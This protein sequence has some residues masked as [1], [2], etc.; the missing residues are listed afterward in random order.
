MML[1]VIGVNRAELI[2]VKR[3]DFNKHFLVTRGQLYKIYPD[4]LSRC[5]VYDNGDR[6]GDEE[7]IVYP[8]NGIIP[9]H[10]RRQLYTMTKILSEIDNHKNCVSKKGIFGDSLAAIGSVRSVWREISFM[11][12]MVVAGAILLYAMVFQ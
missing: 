12:P 1:F 10:P 6:M 7:I 5:F 9:Y 4:G 2:K 3:R 8:E 11:V